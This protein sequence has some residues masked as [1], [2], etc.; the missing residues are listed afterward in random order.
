[1]IDIFMSAPKEGP[2][3]L[4]QDEQMLYEEKLSI[5]RWWPLCNKFTCFLQKASWSAHQLPK[6]SIT[7]SE[8]INDKLNKQEQSSW[9]KPI[10]IS[11][12]WMDNEQTST[13]SWKK[14]E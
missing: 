8:S 9:K 13:A 12:T 7:K 11:L 4:P 14:N 6:Y 3:L 2:N 1:M 10:I 5:H